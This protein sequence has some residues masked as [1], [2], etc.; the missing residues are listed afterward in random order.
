VIEDSGNYYKYDGDEL[1]EHGVI[2][3]L[4]E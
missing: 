4:R 1:T 2:K 3:E